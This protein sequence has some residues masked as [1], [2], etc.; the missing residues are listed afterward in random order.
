[1]NEGKGRNKTKRKKGRTIEGERNKKT[2][3]G[4][5]EGL[6]MYFIKCV[7]STRAAHHY[8]TQQAALMKDR[9]YLNNGLSFR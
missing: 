2:K 7:G 9:L 4:R 5:K 1:M 8:E 6:N 3:E